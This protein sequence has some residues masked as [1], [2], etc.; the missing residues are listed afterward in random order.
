VSPGPR[1][2]SKGA[3]SEV[4]GEADGQGRSRGVGWVCGKRPLCSL[5]DAELGQEKEMETGSW[6]SGSRVESV[7]DPGAQEE[8]L[9]VLLDLQVG[10]DP[11]P[12]K[13]QGLTWVLST[14][15]PFCLLFPLLSLI[16][17]GLCSQK[18]LFWSL[19]R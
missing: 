16:T 13:G 4:S 3:G 2:S 17:V 5:A 12:K 18:R 11:Q 9:N 7:L 8:V 19:A 1:G 10:T 15:V 6:A 14:L